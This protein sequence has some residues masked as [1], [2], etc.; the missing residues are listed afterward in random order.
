MID[1]YNC[2]P[3][4]DCNIPPDIDGYRCIELSDDIYK[5]EKMIKIS[6]VEVVGKNGREF[7]KMLENGHYEISIQDDGKTIKLF[8]KMQQQGAYFNAN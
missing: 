5:Y 1:V 8:E 2:K 6:R 7:V 4:Y 3:F